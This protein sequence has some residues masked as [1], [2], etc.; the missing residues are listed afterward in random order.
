MTKNQLAEARAAVEESKKYLD[1]ASQKYPA[2]H[3]LKKDRVVNLSKLGTLFSQEG[4]FVKAAE[5]FSSGIALVDELLAA[6]VSLPANYRMIMCNKLGEVFETTEQ[7]SEAEAA[8]GE[9]LSDAR[10]ISEADP[11]NPV[12][13]RDLGIALQH[14]GDVARKQQRIDEAE[15]FYQEALMLRR[16]LAE[17]DRMHALNQVDLARTCYFMGEV[18]VMREQ[19]E[20]ARKYFNEALTILKPF[21]E[22]GVLVST[23]DRLLWELVQE[24]TN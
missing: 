19:D 8:F 9:G 21:E 5:T 2:S 18:A 24:S 7:W 10:R 23:E 13:T 17:S 11:S 16:T 12:A 1:K 15:A 3:L 4:D 14:Q 20:A 6:K 22:R